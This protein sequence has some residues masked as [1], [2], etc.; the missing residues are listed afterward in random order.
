M[1]R[2][3]RKQFIHPARAARPDVSALERLLRQA[4]QYFHSGEL[5]QAEALCRKGIALGPSLSPF[6]GQLG[7]TL[8]AQGKL[9]EAVESYRR[10]L[11]L[12]PGCAD[13]HHNLGMTLRDAGK[14]DEAIEQYR[15][16]LAARPDYFEALLNLA[17]TLRELG[18][19]AEA[20]EQYEEAIKL[21]PEYLPAHLNLGLALEKED[22]LEGALT[23]FYKVLETDPLVPPALG[24]VANSLKKLG[25]PAEAIPYLEKAI[26]ADP[27]LVF[28]YHHLGG[29]LSQLNRVEDALRCYEQ[30]RDVNPDDADT[31][32]NLGN[33]YATQERFQEAIECYHKA[34]A[35]RPQF[36]EAHNN[37]GNTL[38]SLGSIGESMEMFEKALAISPDFFEAHSNLGNALKDQGRFVES[39]AAYQRAIDL[40]PSNAGYV[41]NKALSEVS[42]GDLANGWLDYE[43]GFA[44]KQRQPNRP[45][46]QPRWDG[47]SLTG[48]TILT[49]GEQGVG[50]EIMFA[51][52][53]PDLV[54]AADR[55][56]VE[57]DPRLVSLLARSFPD[58][59]V[60][61]RVNPSDG[62]TSWPD[63]DLQ[64]PMGSLP[65]WLRPNVE[66]FPQKRSYLVPDAARVDYWHKRLAELGPG[67][68]V[69]VSWRSR[70]MTAN[71]TKHYVA[72]D[73]WGPIFQVPGVHFINTQYGECRDELASA[74]ERFGIHIHNFGDLD[75]KDALDEVAA[76]TAALDLVITISNIM[77]DMG[78]ALGTQT[79]L[80]ALKDNLDW[81]NLG[82]DYAPWFPGVRFFYRRWDGT[83]E[84]AVG[85]VASELAGRAALSR[86]EAA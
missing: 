48:K 53:I 85:Q 59:E 40:D 28:A 3:K 60:V 50:D 44:C 39:I 9:P 64:V 15:M 56:V 61:P 76:L 17:N 12:A 65:R 6:H 34:M 73:Q 51:S 52:C 71:R 36:A 32:N 25:R 23:C 30:A 86:C 79:W 72:L 8:R 62:R 45:F 10:T 38:R 41:W 27:K 2:S 70:L 66:S 69:G 68:K 75:I 58:A 11:E 46:P 67:L 29:I 84:D 43:A 80:F 55:C 78:G 31:C 22:R 35:Q 81:L 20:I 7:N 13:T 33:V 4:V 21:R 54:T 37:L 18:R 82:V 1:G 47:S 42:C 26:A 49:W 14:P 19:I 5:Q 63:I 74:E 16:A 57:C 83:W 24:G 77:M